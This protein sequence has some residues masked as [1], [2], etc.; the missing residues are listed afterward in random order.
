[1]LD[2]QQ[3]GLISDQVWIYNN[4]VWSVI[5][6]EFTTIRSDQWSSMHLQ[7]YG[8]I[9][10]QVCVYNNTGWSVIKYVFTTIRSDQWSS[11]CLQQSF[12]F[13]IH[14]C[15]YSAKVTCAFFIIRSIGEIH[16]NTHFS[17][18]KLSFPQFWLAQGLKGTVHC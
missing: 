7:Q 13:F 1:M 10:D 14:M 2:L 17:K 12:N 15:G 5:K 9:S 11:M 18:K 8:R 6:Y 16:R 3:Y 4:M